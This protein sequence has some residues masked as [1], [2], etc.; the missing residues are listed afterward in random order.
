[1]S[2]GVPPSGGGRFIGA[3]Q[4][5]WTDPRALV[6]LYPMSQQSAATV[7]APPEGEQDIPLEPQRRTPVES[8]T[9][10]A[11]AMPISLAASVVLRGAA[12]TS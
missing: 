10:A 2:P 1:M 11:F 9:H 3:V 4:M 8:G 12:S 6:Q 7:Q 5:P